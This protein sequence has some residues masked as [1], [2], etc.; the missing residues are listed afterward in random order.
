MIYHER[1]NKYALVAHRRSIRII[2]EKLE[3]STKQLVGT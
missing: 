1:K 2:A 3:L